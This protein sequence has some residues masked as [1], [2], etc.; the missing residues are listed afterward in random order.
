MQSK[1]LN[2]KKINSEKIKEIRKVLRSP[3]KKLRGITSLSPQPRRNANS[4]P[5]RF[6]HQNQNQLDVV[7]HEK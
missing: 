2:V 7:C 5:K 3:S 1:Q 4:I 6:R